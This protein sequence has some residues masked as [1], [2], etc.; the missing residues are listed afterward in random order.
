MELN[1]NLKIIIL[2]LFTFIMIY[3]CGDSGTDTQS[4]GY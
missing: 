4:L 3:S 1:K 2:L